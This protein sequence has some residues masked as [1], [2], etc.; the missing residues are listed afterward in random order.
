MPDLCEFIKF[1]ISGK[2]EYKCIV[3]PELIIVELEPENDFLI[4]KDLNEIYKLFKDDI[5]IKIIET[6][7]PMILVEEDLYELFKNKNK[8]I[9]YLATKFDCEL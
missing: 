2:E 9:E 3:T 7:K 4:N 1:R 6:T 5:K 8:S